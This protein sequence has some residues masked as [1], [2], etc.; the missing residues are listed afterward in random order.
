MMQVQIQN[1]LTVQ[2]CLFKNVIVYDV[3]FTLIVELLQNLF[4][5]TPVLL[6]KTLQNGGLF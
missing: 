3:V 6:Y 1:L 5:N 4:C 2:P